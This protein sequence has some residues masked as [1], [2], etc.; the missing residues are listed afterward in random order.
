MPSFFIVSF[1]VERPR[2][3]A[4]TLDGVFVLAGFQSGGFVVGHGAAA[5][6]KSPSLQLLAK[7][8][9]NS[10]EIADQNDIAAGITPRE[11]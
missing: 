8:E 1:F 9:R 2:T 7:S 10:A 3:I 6:R 11:Q 5:G 4:G